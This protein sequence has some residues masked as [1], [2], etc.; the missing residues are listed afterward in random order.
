MNH[1]IQIASASS[2]AD[3]E[4]F[5]VCRNIAGIIGVLTVLYFLYLGLIMVPESFRYL[6]H[7]KK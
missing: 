7:T 6:K 1:L 4:W 3:A 5:D 2:L